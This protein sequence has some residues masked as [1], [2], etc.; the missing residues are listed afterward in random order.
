MRFIHILLVEDFEAF[1][2][3]VCSIL[4]QRAEFQIAEASDGLEALWKTERLQPDLVLLDIGLPNLNGI[5][6]SKCARRVAPAA[7]IVFLSQESSPEVVQEALCTG[8]LGYVQKSHAESDLLTAIDSVLKGRRFISSGLI[9]LPPQAGQNSKE[10]EYPWQQKVMDAFRASRDS[11]PLRINVAERA[12]AA[13]LID[14]SQNDLGE[15]LALRRALRSLRTL[16]HET[17]PRSTASD[18]KDIA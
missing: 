3:L 10:P 15:H 6:V 4:R 5:E 7:K 14:R 11:L 1:R 12:I 13:R 2:R 9:D 17:G 18:K 16:M 8:G